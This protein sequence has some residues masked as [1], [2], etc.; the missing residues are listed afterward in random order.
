MMGGGA[1]RAL[2][3]GNPSFSLRA[4]LCPDELGVKPMMVAWSLLSPESLNMF[5]SLGHPQATPCCGSCFLPTLDPQT[6]L[7]SGEL[8]A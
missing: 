3:C 6:S 4:K 2:V 8:Q 5:H 7:A 1:V